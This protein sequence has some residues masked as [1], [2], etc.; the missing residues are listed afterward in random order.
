MRLP[1]PTTLFQFCDINKASF[2]VQRHRREMRVLAA[3]VYDRQITKS[4]DAWGVLYVGLPEG[5]GVTHSGMA[6]LLDAFAINQY[7]EGKL[8]SLKIKDLDIEKAIALL[9]TCILQ[10]RKNSAMT[11]TEN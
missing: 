2:C 5:S 8:I 3:F 1:I 7:A 6:A 10:R 11:C 4:G 9:N